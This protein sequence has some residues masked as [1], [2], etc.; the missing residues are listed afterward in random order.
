M[1]DV[2]TIIKE[3]RCGKCNK[4][5]LNEEDAESCCEKVRIDWERADM[6]ELKQIHLDLLKETYIYWN[7]CEFG[8]PGIYCKKPYGNSDVEND[9][10]EIIKL[11]K[12]GNFNY[13]EEEW[14]EKAYD[15]MKDL[16]A[17]TQIALEIILHCQTFRLGRYKKKNYREWTFIGGK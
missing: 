11:K 15:Y 8:A 16:H 13:E 6:F 12:K 10:A 7:S 3:Y 1:V 4:G 5:Y 2:K 14:N 17:Q 9:I